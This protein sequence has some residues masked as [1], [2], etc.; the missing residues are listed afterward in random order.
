MQVRETFSQNNFKAKTF[1]VFLQIQEFIQCSG[2]P[3][4]FYGFC[5]GTLDSLLLKVLPVNFTHTGTSELTCQ[6]SH[7]VENFES[8]QKQQIYIVQVLTEALTLNFNFNFQVSN[9]IFWFTTSEW[10]KML[11]CI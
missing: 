3:S 6:P 4:S 5:E 11:V 8:P 7:S 1:T 2:G 10:C 9:P